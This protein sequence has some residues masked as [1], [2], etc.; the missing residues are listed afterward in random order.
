[1]KDEAPRS[2]FIG[3]PAPVTRASSTRKSHGSCPI[4]HPRALEAR[5]TG[6]WNLRVPME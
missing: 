1:M 6:A 2:V 5:V 3:N 4:P